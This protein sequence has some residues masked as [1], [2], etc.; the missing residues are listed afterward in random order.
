MKIFCTL[1][2]VGI[3]FLS[4]KKEKKINATDIF[5]DFKFSTKIVDADGQSTVSVSV[6]V[7]EDAS[8]DRLNVM[9]SSTEGMFTTSGTSK[10]TVKAAY[11][12]GELIASATWK[13][14]FSPG[15][16]SISVQ[17]EFD[18]PLREFEL[19]ESVEMQISAPASINIEP[20]AFGISS[21]FLNEVQLVARLKNS[22]GKNVSSGYKVRF[23]DFILSNGQPANGRLRAV[24]DVTSD[25]SKVSC[26]YAANTFPVGTNLQLVSVLLDSAE[27]ETSLADT[28]LITINQ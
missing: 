26:Y 4:C 2:I 19:S 12:N 25:S 22:K 23:K 21:N 28:T 13:S 15:I 16:A 9:F 10:Q 1:L 24:K 5:E 6:K 7:S 17:P 20:S 18:S 14:S 11:V 27:N 3:I 8:A